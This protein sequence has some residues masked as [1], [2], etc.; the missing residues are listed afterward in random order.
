M[1]KGVLLA[2][3]HGTRLRPLTFSGNKHMLPI[4]NE[5]M[6]FYALRDLASV[7][8]KEVAI[9]LGPLAEGI[10]EEVGVGAAFGL[11][12]SYI[13]QEVPRGIAD[14]V[15]LARGF[16][17]DDPF[18]VY[19]GD[20]LLEQGARALVERFSR[21]DAAAVIAAARVDDPRRYGI[22]ELDGERI[23]SLAEKPSAPRSSLGLVGVYVFDPQIFPILDSLTPSAR[24]EFEI[25]EAIDRLRR[26]GAH[27]AVERIQGWWKDTGLP[28]DYLAANR[29]VLASRPSEYF[30]P[31]PPGV[32]SEC[33]RGKVRIGTGTT[34]D[35][36]ARIDGPTVLGTGVT[37]GPSTH[38]G[39]YCSV[40]NGA[41]IVGAT[42]RAS[43]VMDRAHI[44]GPVE[45][46]E[47]IVGRDSEVATG[48]GWKAPISLI[49]G[50][51][52]R[53]RGL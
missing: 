31:I 36:S 13:L 32:P 42:V 28:E 52:A 46:R 24:G 1:L 44:E 47:S 30:G 49:V 26:G 5:P 22:V 21:G 50:D 37:I 23:V 34:I 20:N 25:T 41:R 7:G 14:A 45:L 16:V 33:L 51:A 9:V 2:G 6:L 10:R 39:P 29:E 53:L 40:G 19:L 17:G 35:R 43:I 8:V 4:A 18:V 48:T 11:R 38:I 12:V 3:G 15:R 27:V